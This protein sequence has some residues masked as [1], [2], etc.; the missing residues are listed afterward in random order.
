MSTPPQNDGK[1]QVIGVLSNAI[2]IELNNE[3]VEF[4]NG[5]AKATRLSHHIDFINSI[6]GKD[7]YCSLGSIESE[8]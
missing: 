4:C 2:G 1:K 6:V 5:K 3:L 8:V 7:N